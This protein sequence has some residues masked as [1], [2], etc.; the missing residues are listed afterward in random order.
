M[1]K[2]YN[3]WRYAVM[4]NKKVNKFA[5]T[6][7]VKTTENKS[8]ETVVPA[9][10]PVEAKAAAPEVKAPVDAKAEVKTEAEKEE[11]KP[12]AKKAPAKKEEAP[13]EKAVKKAPEKDTAK[14]FIEFG[15]NKFAADE[16]VEKCKAAYKADNSRKQ[17][18][19]IEVYVKPEDNKAY[20]VVNGKADGLYIDL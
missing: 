1:K 4:A 16:I 8:A 7:T 19:S 10:A 13:A 11:K 3:Y 17:V 9:A 5:N 20:Y 14:L 18:R 2:T 15:G 6:N 12:A